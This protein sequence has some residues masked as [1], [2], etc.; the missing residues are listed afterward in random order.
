MAQGRGLPGKQPVLPVARDE[1][2]VSQAALGRKLARFGGDIGADVRE[3][4][5][6]IPRARAMVGQRLGAI[7]VG[8]GLRRLLR[9]RQRGLH[10]I[11]PRLV[12]AERV[13]RALAAVI[14]QSRL[15]RC[16]SAVSSLARAMPENRRRTGRS[17]ALRPKPE[18][19]SASCRRLERG[20]MEC[21]EGPASSKTRP[22]VERV[23]GRFQRLVLGG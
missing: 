2:L 5:H 8:S 22:S 4:L 12:V 11:Q 9:R 14:L 13:L 6:V 7:R 1:R 16:R 15:A 3:L 10:V 20:V 18:G 19:S 23:A 21:G 17:P